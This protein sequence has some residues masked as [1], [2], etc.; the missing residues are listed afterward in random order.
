MG[1]HPNP[2]PDPDRWVLALTLTLTLTS[3]SPSAL[4][5]SLTLLAALLATRTQALALAL[6]QVLTIDDRIPFIKR[7][8][9]YGRPLF[10]KPTKEGEFWPCLL[11]KAFAKVRVRVRVS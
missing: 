9:Y 8:G 3:P 5:L 2:N 10:C 11:E 7:E 1:A 4:A 6:T